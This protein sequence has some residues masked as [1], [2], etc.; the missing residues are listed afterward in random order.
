MRTLLTGVPGRAGSRLAPRLAARAPLRVLVRDP[1]RVAPYWDQGH[2]VVIGDLRDPDA[3]KR[4]VHGV[5]A[6]VHL[7][8]AFRGVD[9]AETV[10]V[11]RDAAAPLGRAALGAG[12]GR[13][14][15]RRSRPGFGPRRGAPGPRGDR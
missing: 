15:V 10:A 9:E 4:A 5:D 14:G 11:N 13:V 6:V 7:A 2:D 8:A 1:D 3:V 12:G